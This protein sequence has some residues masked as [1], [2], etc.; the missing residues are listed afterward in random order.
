M[1]P[2]SP[3]QKR[4]LDYIIEF[5]RARGYAPS[6][7]DVADGCDISSSSLAQ[8]HL[9]VLERQ[10]YIHRD[11]EISRSIALV[12]N[13]LSTNSIP[14]VGT[15]AAG[16]PIPV[17]SPDTWV[18]APEELLEL[19]GYVTGLLDKVYGLR[20]QGTSMIDAL[21]DDGD[22]VILQAA[23]TAEDGEMVAVWLKSRQEVTLKKLYRE[24]ER[25]RLQPA[26]EAM[27]P[28]YVDPDEIEVQGRVIAVLRKYHQHLA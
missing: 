1:E 23:S 14:L 8:Y 13:K 19:P 24:P 20:V 21:V 17:P 6:V 27:A 2:I 4:I 12:K 5:T 26:N 7:R 11:P 16:H 15:I 3:K 28:I 10:G 18:S 25:I 9:K 22:I